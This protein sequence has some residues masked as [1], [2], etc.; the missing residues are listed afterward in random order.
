MQ[1]I[2]IAT[3]VIAVI[4]FVGGI[5]ANLFSAALYDLGVGRLSYRGRE[6][7]NLVGTWK[8]RVELEGIEPFDEVVR[9]TGQVNRRFKGTYTSPAIGRLES[10]GIVELDIEGFLLD[11][12]TIRYTAQSRR[13][14]H[15]DYVTGLAVVSNDRQRIEGLSISMGI[16]TYKPTVARVVFT[17]VG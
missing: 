4:S 12:R 1:E 2:T 3:A 5:V 10:V 14:K 8:A 11:H 9:I 7:P 6:Y 13:Q 16:L 17:F 15:V